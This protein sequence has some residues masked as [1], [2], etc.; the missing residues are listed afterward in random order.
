MHRSNSTKKFLSPKERTKYGLPP[1]THYQLYLE[2]LEFYHIY[3]SNLY[4]DC[5]WYRYVDDVLFVH[6]QEF[7]IQTFHN[8][9]NNL[10]P[11]IKFTI[12]KSHERSIPFLDMQLKW[13]DNN[14]IV[15]TIYRKPTHCPKYLHW[16]SA[17]KVSIKF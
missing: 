6:P 9:I 2:L 16:F 14:E 3:R 1:V 5:H 4:T 7:D 17:H 11:S 13:P 15:F 8:Y 12:E 10:H